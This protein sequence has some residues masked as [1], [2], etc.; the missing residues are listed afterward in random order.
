MCANIIDRAEPFTLQ[1]IKMSFTVG[2]FWSWNQSNLLSNTLRGA[3]AEFIVAKALDIPLDRARDDWT[4]FDLVYQAKDRPINIEVKSSAYIQA[5]EQ[6][7][8]STISFSIA[9]SRAWINQKYIG[10]PKRHAHLYVFCLHAFQDLERKND[11]NPLALDQWDFFIIDTIHLN[12]LP[13]NQR[14]ISLPSLISLAPVRCTYLELKATIDSTI[15]KITAVL[16]DSS[17]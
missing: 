16:T 8:L 4:P 6:C 1:D 11:A 3:L 5:W 12:A 10:E 17:D 9:P 7:K 13:I 2:D 14:S 15:E